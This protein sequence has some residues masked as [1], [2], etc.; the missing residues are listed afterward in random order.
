MG[1]I[2]GGV[3]GTAQL[4]TCQAPGSLS[5]IGLSGSPDEATP[6]PCW[7]RRSGWDEE[8]LCLTPAAVYLSVP[9]RGRTGSSTCLRPPVAPSPR[10]APATPPPPACCLGSSQEVTPKRRRP[11]LRAQR[12]SRL[13]GTGDSGVTRPRR[14]ATE[15]GRP[16]PAALAPRDAT[17]RRTSPSRSETSA[18]PAPGVRGGGSPQRGSPSPRAPRIR[19]PG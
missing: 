7:L 18:V 13:R 10:R 1:R 14:G 5:G 4:G 2:L 3:V 11:L 9:K 8:L 16:P 17:S 12:P 15:G 6:A 19:W